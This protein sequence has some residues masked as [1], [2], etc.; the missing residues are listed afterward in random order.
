[1]NP[2]NTLDMAIQ[3]NNE[4]IARLLSGDDRSAVEAF[5]QSLSMVKTIHPSKDQSCTTS[6][7][8]PLAW[9]NLT[10]GVPSE[11]DANQLC[12]ASFLFN[13]PV[14]CHEAIPLTGIIQKDG[15]AFIYRNA[16][17]LLST[18]SST[19]NQESYNVYSACIVFNL[20]LVHYSHGTALGVAKAEAMYGMILALLRG[21][22][23]T[24]G[25]AL[26]LRLA[27]TNNISQILYAKGD[28]RRARE[29]L[30]GLAS[31]IYSSEEYYRCL[32]NAQEWDGL[33]QNILL[34]NPL[35]P[36]PAA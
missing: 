20:A 30:N 28:Y 33:H 10:T 9:K 36:A 32:F 31:I 15:D 2:M 23:S 1:M 12:M 35:R 24:N 25:T 7:T 21:I 34:L 14:T 4:G 8:L 3:W 11:A 16:F 18:G 17:R 22:P 19:C 5:S 29:G 6:N 27:A 13:R 26:L